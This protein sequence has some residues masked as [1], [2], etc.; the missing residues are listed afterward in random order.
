MS[1]GDI[2]F[3]YRHMIVDG[4]VIFRKYHHPF[5]KF[6][7]I[8]THVHPF[9]VIW[10]IMQRLDLVRLGNY[11]KSYPLKVC[12]SYRETFARVFTCLSRWTKTIPTSSGFYTAPSASPTERDNLDDLISYR[13]DAKRFEHALAH[14]RK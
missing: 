4:K 12:A 6:P 13:S 7:S 1:S 10:H 2:Q 3:I 14:A 9:Y 11:Y 8:T 5:T